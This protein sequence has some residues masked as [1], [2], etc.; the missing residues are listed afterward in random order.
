VLAGEFLLKP[1]RQ[2]AELLVPERFGLLELPV[3][4]PGGVSGWAF[5]VPA[6]GDGVGG[7]VAVGVAL[8]RGCERV[9]R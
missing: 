1:C 5:V 2:G 3:G 9:A 7:Q 6:F 8:H 4:G